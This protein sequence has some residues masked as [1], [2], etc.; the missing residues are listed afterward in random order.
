MVA[1]S[2]KAVSECFGFLE[3][4]LRHAVDLVKDR[5]GEVKQTHNKLQGNYK[6]D[7]KVLEY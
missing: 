3:P 4:V 6:K 7:L 5:K 2:R 1:G